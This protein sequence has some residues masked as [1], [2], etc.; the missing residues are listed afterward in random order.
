MY[1][2]VKIRKVRGR[3]EGGE[4]ESGSFGWLSDS[5]LPVGSSQFC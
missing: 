1:E 5:Q 4:R 3:K 2:I